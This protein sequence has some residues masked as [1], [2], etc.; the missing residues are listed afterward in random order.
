MERYDKGIVHR[1]E[2]RLNVSFKKLSEKKQYQLYMIE[3][4][5][6]RNE[7]KQAEILLQSD[8]DGK[9]SDLHRTLFDF[10]EEKM[11][12]AEESSAE[13][14]K[15][16][17]KN[18]LS[19]AAVFQLNDCEKRILRE[20]ARQT[21]MITNPVDEEAVKNRV[22]RRAKN[23]GANTLMDKDEVFFSGVEKGMMYREELRDEATQYLQT[24]WLEKK[25]F[26]EQ[27]G[28]SRTNFYGDKLRSDYVADVRETYLKSLPSFG[29][30]EGTD[31][32][33]RE[34]NA[35]IEA[36]LS[37]DAEYAILMTG[38]ERLEA[39]LERAV[40]DKEINQNAA[41]RNAHELDAT[42]ALLD[43]ANAKLDYIRKK[44][45]NEGI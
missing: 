38:R 43:K 26:A 10:V 37:R 42:K 6:M 31:D 33:I 4:R 17:S 45:P 8:D 7:K 40:K 15:I 18:K 14:V 13:M 16:P 44:Y 36:M 24:D 20:E 3:Q 30:P 34:L 27:I 23:L 25:A 2:N 5:I 39:E 32:K 12:R 11:I 9:L 28:W 19:K 35:R 22:Y 21:K 41:R 29:P 1:I